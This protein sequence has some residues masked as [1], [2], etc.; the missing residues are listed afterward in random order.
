VHRVRVQQKGIELICRH[1]GKYYYDFENEGTPSPKV[2]RLW[3]P[4]WLVNNLRIDYFHHMA[5]VRIEDPNFNDEDLDLLT[6]CLPRIESLGI[7]GTSIADSGLTH[8]CGNRRL[9]ALFLGRKRG[10]ETRTQLVYRERT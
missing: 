1:G 6:A 7:D 5:W 10:T 9:M 4:G 2:P 8:L 3:P